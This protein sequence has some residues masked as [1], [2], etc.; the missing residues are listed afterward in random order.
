[1]LDLQWQRHVSGLPPLFSCVSKGK[2]LPGITHW[3]RGETMLIWAEE[4]VCER[5]CLQSSQGKKIPLISFFI[6]YRC[7]MHSFKRLARDY[8]IFS[9]ARL[10]FRCAAI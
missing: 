1:M 7:F 8:S 9:S 2:P 3:G 10:K 4:K 5:S 6:I